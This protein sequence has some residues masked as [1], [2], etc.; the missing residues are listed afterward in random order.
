MASRFHLLWGFVSAAIVCSIGVGAPR[1]FR[2]LFI[3]RRWEEKTPQ[4]QFQIKDGNVDL[5]LTV[6]GKLIAQVPN[7]D[8]SDYFDSKT[9]MRDAYHA[10]FC[11]VAYD[12][13][14]MLHADQADSSFGNGKYLPLIDK[15]NVA[16]PQEVRIGYMQKGST[17]L[18][19]ETIKCN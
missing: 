15:Y 8:V 14:L 12:T 10:K 11:S 19:Y 16:A 3:E 7:E 2:A 6:T 17:S 13:T 9:E 1:D 4:A 18:R 5:N